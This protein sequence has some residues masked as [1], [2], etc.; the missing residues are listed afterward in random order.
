[1]AIQ[2]LKA[3]VNL[4]ENLKVECSSR[5]F[6]FR[7]DQSEEGGGDNTAMCP[8]EALLS[9]LG[10]CKC[11]V[12]RMLS[13]SSKISLENLRIE[14]EADFDPDGFTGKSK[15]AKIG[16]S[17][18]VT[19]YFIKANNTEEEMRQFIERIEST[20]PIKDTIENP[21]EMNYEVTIE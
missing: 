15:V 5:G 17:R 10:G 18:I 20:C 1:M 3:E 4:M 14:L 13:K 16:L 7:L 2:I 11:M 9:S 21:P 12:A 19:R 8:G 6:S